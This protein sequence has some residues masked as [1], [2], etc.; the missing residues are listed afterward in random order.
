ML[1]AFRQATGQTILERYGMTEIGMALSNPYD[2]P[3]VPGAVG[4]ELPGVSVDI[5]DEAGRPVGGGR[6]GRAARAHA[7]DVLGVPR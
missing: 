7:A 2:G 1:E 6:A 4:R 3:R 5:V